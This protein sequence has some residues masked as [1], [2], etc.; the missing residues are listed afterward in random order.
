MI[1]IWLTRS[2]NG[3]KQHYISDAASAF[4]ELALDRSEEPVAGLA[5]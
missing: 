1:R 2:L 5:R 4:A 3:V